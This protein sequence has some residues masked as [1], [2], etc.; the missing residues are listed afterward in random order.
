SGTIGGNLAYAEA[1]S[2]PAPALLC[3]DA[4]VRVAGPGRERVVPIARFFRGFYE[5]A[6]EPG[7]IVTAVRVPRAPA[8]ARGGYVKYTARSAEDK[9]LVGVPA[10]LALDAVGRCRE[11]RIAD[12]GAAAAPH[13]PARGP[14][15]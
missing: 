5:A 6:L 4:E 9:P 11:A 3:L 14:R 1:A 12:G 15:G 13:R 8:G 7:E 10:L 2:D